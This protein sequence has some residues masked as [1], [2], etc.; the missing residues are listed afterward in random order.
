MDDP[1]E[2]V[3]RY[4]HVSSTASAPGRRT[5]WRS[6]SSLSDGKSARKCEPR[7]SS[8]VSALRAT[9]RVSSV[10]RV[11]QALEAL[12]VADEAAVAPERC[13]QLRCHELRS[14]RSGSVGK[15]V[16]E[17]GLGERRERR[18]AAEDEALEQRVRREPVRSVHAG[19]SALARRVETREL[20]ASV[21]IGENAADGVVRRRRDRDRRL[22]RVVPLLDE[23]PHE[24]REAPAV[25]RAQIEQ[26]G[27]PCGDLAG[28]DVARGELVGE[29]VALVVE[30][31]GALAAQRLGEE[32]RRIDERRRM[33]LDE[34]EIGQCRAR[35]VRGRHAL[36]HCARRIRGSL[37][38][39]GG[40]TRRKERRA[41]RDRAPVG[42]DADAALVV[43]PDRE[44]SL[45]LGNGDPRVR[46]D[47]FRELAGDAVAG[48]GASCVHDATE[49]VSTL[50]AEAL[51]ELD[52]ELDEIA[53]PCGCLVGQHR[54]GAR[55]TEPAAGPKRVLGMQ[56]RVVVL[57]HCCCDAALGE[58]ARGREQRSLRENEDVT[59]GRSTERGEEPGDASAD[60][61]ERELG[62][63]ACISGYAHGSFR[64]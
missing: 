45:A 53:D 38:Q 42:H 46:E 44:H 52:T 9:S 35:A 37:P 27:S 57:P 25:D 48:R 18:A 50:E 23:A 20:A 64:L 60:D 39:R 59:L 41:C 17:V 12:G 13:P 3:G 16:R 54:D 62:V 34:L 33:E 30:K 11:E 4:C 6:N 31:K 49:A 10:R 26:H 15:P 43:A 63:L 8:R 40:A 55:A 36:A 1:L 24:R 19:R 7:L 21:E 47:A 29:A 14:R 61:D 28:D 56:R 58:E 22:R 32:Q 51:V 2:R 5:T